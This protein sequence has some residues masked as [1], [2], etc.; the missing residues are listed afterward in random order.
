MSV[1]KRALVLLSGGIDSAVAL[2]WAKSQRWNVSTLTFLFPGRRKKEIWAAKNLERLSG[3][4]K[5]ERLFLPFV[6][7]PDSRKSCYIP[8]RNLMYYGIAASLAEKMSAQFIL[9]GHIG[10]DAR[11]FPD[12]TPRYFKV[13]NRLIR[14]NKNHDRDPQLLFPLIRLSK[15]KIIQMGEKL[16]VPF[17][18]TWSC[19]RDVPKPCWECSS[20]RERRSG[21]MEAGIHDPLER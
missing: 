10:H 19:S 14:W 13:L 17:Q 18:Y 2:W 15:K 16:K 11:V 7:P 12:A 9:G 1:E 20:C 8:Q 5:N 6:D 21:F 3:C 4:D